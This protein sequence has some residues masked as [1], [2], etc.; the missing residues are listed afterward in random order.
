MSSA[1]TPARTSN[2]PATLSADE[3]ERIGR[4]VAASIAPATL[5]AYRARLGTWSSWCEQTGRTPCPAD[6]ESLAAFLSESADQGRSVSWLGQLLAAVRW[7]HEQSGHASPT[8][9]PGVRA[10][11]AGIR[12]SVGV[13]PNRKAPATVDRLSAMVAHIDRDSSIGKRDAAVLLLGFAGAFRRSELVALDVADLEETDRGLL[14]TIRRSKTDQEGRGRQVAILPG[15][16]RELCPVAAVREWLAAAE[17]EDG[18]VFRSVSRWGRP[19]AK[20]SA[21]IVSSIVKRYAESAGLEPSEFAGHS[22][23]AGLV[24]S[25]AERGAK[26]AAI[27]AITGHKSGEMISVYTR[28]VD[29]FVDHAAEGLL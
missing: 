5:R 13:A 16:R 9:H 19:G 21:R 26:T 12:R 15:S 28:R 22:L 3:A 18:P 14:V 10:C 11:M 20:L 7:S 17:I 23:R 8:A 2:L 6:P 4:Y 25:A 24:T 29:A 27:R 1:I